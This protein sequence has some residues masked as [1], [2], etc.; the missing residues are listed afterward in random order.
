MAVAKLAAPAFL[1]LMV[2]NCP[3]AVADDLNNLDAN[4][5]TAVE[6]AFPADQGSVQFQGG[7]RY[8]RWHRRDVVRFYPQLQVGLASRLQ[9]ALSLPYSVGSGRRYGESAAGGSLLYQLNDEQGLLPAFAAVGEIS[10]PIGP[11]DKSTETA[12]SAIATNTIDPAAKRRLHLNAT[13]LR[14][15]DPSEDE[16]RNRYR[17]MAGYSQE[18]RKDAVL[19]L[20]YIREQQEKHERDANIFEAGVRYQLSERVTLGVG[21]GLGLGR[22]SPRARAILS[23]QFTLGG[24]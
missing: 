7:A 10:K 18:V 24:G 2:A 15:L 3:A 6:D 21:G 8:D 1:A 9:G 11:G 19:V 23:V 12:L 14:S 22:D 16:R 5:P 20:D 13:W 4:L 17:F